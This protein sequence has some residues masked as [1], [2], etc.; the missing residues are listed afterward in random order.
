MLIEY[1]DIKRKVLELMNRYSVAGETI[2]PAY[3]NQ[4]D[5][6]QR[7][8]GLINDAILRIRTE[9]A[10]LVSSCRLGGGPKGEGMR[11]YA[12][13]EG[14]RGVKTGGVYRI[15]NGDYS[16]AADYRLLGN[17]SILLPADGAEYEIEYYFQN[18]DSLRSGQTDFDTLTEDPEVVTAACYYAAAMLLMDDNEFGYAALYNEFQSRMDGMRPLPTAEI[19]PIRD[20]YGF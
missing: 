12:L 5:Y 11:A 10:P 7:I 3:N 6:L 4:S 15:A 17:S 1:G 19:S 2:S 16:P 13:P 9:A 18:P 14:C 20:V 8:P